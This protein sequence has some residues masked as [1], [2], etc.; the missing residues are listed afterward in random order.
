[1]NKKIFYAIAILSLLIMLPAYSGTAAVQPEMMDNKAIGTNSTYNY[2]GNTIEIVEQTADST[3]ILLNDTY[4]LDLTHNSTN[5]GVV[6]TKLDTGGLSPQADE[7]LFDVDFRTDDEGQEIVI[8]LPDYLL[9]LECSGPNGDQYDMQII[10]PP[11]MVSLSYNSTEGTFEI[12]DGLHMI[13]F[14]GKML[15]LD[16]GIAPLG[17]F[18][19]RINETAF[20]IFSPVYGLITANWNAGSGYF[21]IDFFAGLV[22]GPIPGG[23]LPIY[24]DPTI[25]ITIDFN[26]ISI[27]W[28]GMEIYLHALM[29]VIIFDYIIITWYFGYLIERL[30]ILIWDITIIIYITIVELLLVIIYS[31]FEIKFYYEQIV[32]VYEFIEIIFVFVSILI[33]EITFIFHFEFWFIQIIFIININIA[34]ILPVRIILIP[35][36]IPIF[37]TNIYYVPV[38]IIQTVNIYVPYASPALYIDVYDE[39]LGSPTHTIQY[40]VTDQ[41]GLEVD[42]ATVSVNYN[43]TDYPATFEGNGIYEVSIPA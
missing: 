8:E 32:I 31:C 23:F 24:G 9:D 11:E 2:D 15:V 43:G 19:N 5:V 41:A 30:V 39:I 35:I 28:A 38:Y 42:D 27:S 22:D 17:I 25:S 40:K 21:G 4:Q 29:L 3:Q 12:Y 14:D 13:D 33:W 16:M 37:I 10:G 1:M 7:Q 36:I 34:I 26:G 20:E 18:V 6:C